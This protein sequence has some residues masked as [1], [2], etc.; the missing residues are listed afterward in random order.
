MVR[1]ALFL[2]WALIV[3][4]IC[5]GTIIAVNLGAMGYIRAND[6][7]NL[8]LA[9][10]AIFAVMTAYCG[11]L[12]I[13]AG[14]AVRILDEKNSEKNSYLRNVSVTELKDIDNKTDHGWYAVNL[15]EK[16]GLIGTVVG[17]MMALKG[18]G[19]FQN[20]DPS[21]VQRLISQLS[22]GMSTA[23]ITTLVGMVCGILLG[24]QYQNLGGAIDRS[25]LYNE[26]RRG[27]EAA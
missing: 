12:T 18:F 20:S 16:M 3:S 23:L 27:D 8:S 26:K 1:G 6:P 9:I 5:A 2:K 17:V 19:G 10:M 21:A 15:C 7:T 11:K 25:L 14:N 22:I 13:N 4:V 24:L